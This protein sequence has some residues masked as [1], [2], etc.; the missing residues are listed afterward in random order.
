MHDG[1]GA[2]PFHVAPEELQPGGTA[3][4]CVVLLQRWHVGPGHRHT[5]VGVAEE[6]QRGGDEHVVAYPALDAQIAEHGPGGVRLETQVGASTIQGCKEHRHG[7]NLPQDAVRRDGQRPL[8]ARG[9]RRWGRNGHVLQRAGRRDPQNREQLQAPP[10]AGRLMH[11]ERAEERQGRY[12]PTAAL[13][14][15]HRHPAQSNHAVQRYPEGHARNEQ[16]REVECC[17]C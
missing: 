8:A 14:R 2:R 17:G 16:A 4:Y 11:Q 3:G 13:C 9:L 6:L 5:L 12:D 15:R 10:R 1:L 7:C